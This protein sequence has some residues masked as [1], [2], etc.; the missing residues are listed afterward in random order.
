M[1]SATF[2]S[3]A[4]LPAGDWRA[5]APRFQAEAAAANFA[6]AAA[7]AELAAKKGCSP[8]Q[9]AL[10]WLLSRGADVFPIPGT[11][12]PARARENAAAAALALS[13]AEAAEVEAAVPAAL[14]D[15]YEGRHGQFEDRE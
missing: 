8:A 14:G 10:A 12:A 1:L 13:P 9:L 2:G 15:R 5:K 11:K 4:A 7:L 3:P 6:R